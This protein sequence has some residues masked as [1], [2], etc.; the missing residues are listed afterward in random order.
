MLDRA[1]R[2]VASIGRG[3]ARCYVVVM[4]AVV[5]LV[6]MFFLG[7]Q[8]PRLVAEAR[9]HS[10]VI[11]TASS[12]LGQMS[13]R[14]ARGLPAGELLGERGQDPEPGTARIAPGGSTLIVPAVTGLIRS[15]RAVTAVVA[16]AS[17]GTVI[18]SSFPSRYPP[19]RPAATELPPGAADSIAAG[20]VKGAPGGT[21]STPYGD[22]SWTLYGMAGS[23]LPGGGG[24]ASFL[25]VQAPQAIG[26][27]NP[28]QAW[29]ELGQVTD[30]GAL[31]TTVALLL[32][33]PIVALFGLLAS[34]RLVRRIRRLERATVAVVDGDYTFTLPRLRRDEVGRL[35]ENIAV[36]ARQLG[37][38]LAAERDRAT[39]EARAA[40]RSRIAREIHDAISQHLFGLR[41]IASG[42]RRADP[43]NEQA[44]AIERI[45]REAQRDMQALLLELRPAAL[46]GAGLVPA[47]QQVCATYRDRL[48]VT[49]EADLADIV[50][51]EAVEEALLRVAQEACTNAIRHGNA[52]CLTMS[53]KHEDGHVALAIHDDGAGFDPMAQ[54]AGFGLQHIQDRITALGGTVNIDS[55][56]GMGAVVTV[57]VPAS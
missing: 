24:T 9:L 41:M 3:L 44:M 10:A 2:A 54:H 34:R 8:V 26:F 19:G 46:D 18:A 51:P 22:V 16:I 32:A 55:Q 35:E 47:L 50:L 29:D 6:E 52:R 4:V 25:Y 38:A 27:V 20:R 37:S 17:D 45:A 11:G 21:G 31:Y 40:E 33:L 1:R 14:Y 15:D 49:V 5:V 43:E 7:Y 13:E 30:T 42:M 39:S 53:M 28:I 56:L 12:Y 23:T 57:L 48:G 36:M